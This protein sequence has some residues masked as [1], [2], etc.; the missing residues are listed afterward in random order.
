MNSTVGKRHAYVGMLILVMSLFGCLSQGIK[1]PH[2][3]IVIDEGLMRESD[4]LDIVYENGVYSYVSYL[5]SRNLL[6]ASQEPTCT[7]AAQ[8]PTGHT[9]GIWIWDYRRVIGHEEETVG[10]L[11]KEGVR[12][13]YIQVGGALESFRPFLETA[14]ARRISVYALDGSPDYINDYQV[15]IDDMVKIREFNRSARDVGFE[16]IQIDVEPYLKKDFNLRKEYYVRQFLRMAQDLRRHAGDDLKLSFALPFWFDTLTID[17]DKPLSFHIIDIADEVVIMSYRTDYDEIINSAVQELCYA[18]SVGKPL[19]LGLEI[20]NLPDEEH[21]VV[22]KATLDKFTVLTGSGM[23]L[24]KTPRD[25]LPVAKQYGVKS[26]KITFFS[27]KDALPR[28]MSK[29]PQFKSFNGYVIHS[30]EGL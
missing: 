15:L 17:G 4:Y 8:Q 2:Q 16:G 18:S 26:E 12:R 5:K 28:I 20:N 29:A 7:Y 24:S 27:K 19:Y 1:L 9:K 14:K 22:D 21:F 10:R 25:G 23:V 30:Y 6:E 3:A 13:V 11:Q